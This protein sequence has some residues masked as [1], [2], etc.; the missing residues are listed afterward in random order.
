MPMFVFRGGS[1]GVAVLALL[2]SAPHAA[3]DAPSDANTQS[4]PTSMG[5]PHTCT[6]YPERAIENMAQGT[7]TLMF[8]I[9]ADRVPHDIT[10]S[11]TSGNIDLDQAAASCVTNWRYKPATLNGK[12]VAAPWKANVTWMIPT[13]IPPVGYNS[14]AHQCATA[15]LLAMAR[16]KHIRSRAGVLGRHEWWRKGP[17]GLAT[18]LR[19]ASRLRNSQMRVQLDL[20][21][22]ATQ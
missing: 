20:H 19:F 18:E 10:V 22:G 17:A 12:P 11:S 6:E 5:K 14:A 1:I 2:L 9:G 3:A 7:T 4:A 16:S 8:T 13:I 21:A 15:S